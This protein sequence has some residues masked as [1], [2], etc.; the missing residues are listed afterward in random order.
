MLVLTSIMPAFAEEPAVSTETS[1]LQSYG[2][3]EGDGT[4]ANEA[5]VLTR[6]SMTVLLSKLYGDQEIAMDYE[7]PGTF[8]DLEGIWSGFVPYINYAKAMDRMVGYPDNTFKPMDPMSAQAFNSMIV[9]ALGYD[10]EWAD[11]NAKAAELGV[12]V[13]A[14]DPTLVLRGEAFK[15]IRVALDVMPMDAEVTFGTQLGLTNYVAPVVEPTELLVDSVEVLNLKQVKV[16]F[17]QAVDT[18]TLDIAGSD[19]TIKFYMNGSSTM[20]VAEG[21]V[22]AEDAMSTVVTLP[23]MNQ[24]D[25][26]KVVVDGVMNAEELEVTAYE[27]SYTVKDLADP[28]AVSITVDN[29]KQLTIKFTEPMNKTVAAFSLTTNV[30]KID[31]SVVV[32]KITPDHVNNALVVN[33]GS[34]IAVGTHNVWLGKLDD[35]AGFKTA[36]FTQAIELVEDATAPVV[37]AV[38]VVS[39]TKIKVTFDEPVEAIGTITVDEA[40][41]YTTSGHTANADKTVYTMTVDTALG[42]VSL[43][44]ATLNYDGTADVEGNA[45]DEAEFVFTATD[46]AVKPTATITLDGTNKLTI[47]YDESMANAGTITI[48]DAD[49]TE[50]YTVTDPAFKA[51]TDDKVVEIAAATTGLD[52]VDAATYTVEVK[53][54]K[55]GSVRA[56]T[57]TTFTATVAAVDT[58]NPT[59]DGVV[60]TDATV[61]EEEV[62]IYFS[63]QMDAT[64]VTNEEN[65]LVD[66]DGEGAGGDYVSLSSITDASIT[67]NG[68]SIVIAL[69]GADAS[70]DIKVL[71]VKDTVGNTIATAIFNVKQ[72]VAA[73]NTFDLNDIDPVELTAKNKL[74]LTSTVKWGTVDPSNFIISEEGGDPLF[75]GISSEVDATG[76]I[77]TLT[78]N[79]NVSVDALSNANDVQIEV[80]G[81]GVLD[82]QGNALTLAAEDVVDKIAP[83]ATVAAVADTDTTLVLSF[84]EDIEINDE[85]NTVNTDLAS[86]DGAGA[87]ATGQFLVFVDDALVAVDSIDFTDTD[88]ITITYA[89]G[90]SADEVVKVMYVKAVTANAADRVRDIADNEVASF[91]LTTT[92]TE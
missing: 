80:D 51:S 72:D 5:G 73:A 75:V 44:E 46:D 53:S 78:I 47:T 30:L 17:N 19:A 32:A 20:V 67:N 77:L 69:P 12:A 55:D 1:D 60:L 66:L 34:S 63:E 18:D 22:V 70:T 61:D 84:N 58:K 48:T 87:D 83:T 7:L 25:E 33:L 43:V 76:L 26:I 21:Q 86:Y 91:T 49:D 9:R 82:Y 6:A 15:A 28:A 2:V 90:F 10:V 92:V 74:K 29:S 24:S 37:T 88:E 4:G 41:T 79:G 42:L 54:A 23:L 85:D 59:I 68:D 50:I 40:G 3:V 81:T 64:T 45:S 39:P 16:M 8:T 71:L 89:A 14:A 36:E 62:T 38:E 35:F 57:I 13:D 11:V 52:D 27:Y 65:F 56:N 31:D